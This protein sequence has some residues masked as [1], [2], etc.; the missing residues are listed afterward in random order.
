MR[1]QMKESHKCWVQNTHSVMLVG[2]FRL[3]TLHCTSP[4]Q[5]KHVFVP[6]H[7]ILSCKDEHI[8]NSNR[9]CCRI[10]NILLIYKRY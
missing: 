9:Y 7:Y 8:L 6:D 4:G 5:G 2:I 3:K 10:F 1:V